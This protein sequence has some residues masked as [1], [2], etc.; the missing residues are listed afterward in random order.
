MDSY[1]RELILDKT[2]KAVDLAENL[3]E[4]DAETVDPVI[5]I[6]DEVIGDLFGE[7]TDIFDWMG[8]ANRNSRML[9][10]EDFI[11]EWWIIHRKLR[12]MIY[13]ND[14]YEREFQI[15][16]DKEEYLENSKG[17]QALPVYIQNRLGNR[18]VDEKIK[19]SKA[20]KESL[21]LHAKPSFVLMDHPKLQYMVR[22]KK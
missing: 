16:I 13:R 17:W 21:A 9:N 19:I 14:V 2:T 4:Y 3:L 18:N 8:D 7:T 20:M 5:E 1:I 11:E 6:I 10:S 12:R 15:E 22:S